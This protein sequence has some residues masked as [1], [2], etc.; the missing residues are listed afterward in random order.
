ML[1]YVD[2]F[3]RRHIGPEAQDI[4]AMLKVVGAASLDALIEETVPAAI[5][6][7]QP[8]KLRPAR[9]EYELLEEL[10]GIAAR[11]QVMRSCIGLGY[12]DTITPGV[13]LR[14]I[15]LNPG[16]YTQYTPYQAE[17]AQ[18]RLEALLNFQTMIG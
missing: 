4:E 16:W 1:D 3:A 5:R 6:S 10:E 8:L 7:K 11:N 15:F 12:Y 13:I 9:A 17:I 14:N 2:T 18:G